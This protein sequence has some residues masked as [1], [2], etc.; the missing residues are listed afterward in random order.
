M[1]PEP[2]LPRYGERSLCEL[3]PAIKGTRETPG[4]QDLALALSGARATVLVVADGL[5]AL[6]L[7][8]FAALAPL[9]HA[10]Q[11]EPATSVAPSTTAAALTSLTTGATPGIHGIVGYRMRVND[12]VLQTLRWSVNGADATERYRPEAVQTTEPL[13][14]MGAAPVVYVGKAKYA[15]GGFTRA[16]LRGAQYLGVADL[17]AI[18]EQVLVATSLSPLVVAYHDAIDHVAHA[19]G[20]GQ[21]YQHEIVRLESMVTE[22]RHRLP[23]DVAIVVTADHGQRDVGAREVRVPKVFHP[24]IASMSGE[25]R[26][27]WLHA[28]LGEQRNL[29]EGLSEALA[30]SCWVWTRREAIALGLF[31]P[32]VSLDAEDRFG[33]VCLVPFIDAFVLD[34]TEPQEAHMR[35]RHG[36]LTPSE[37]YVP[38]IVR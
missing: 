10:S 11:L 26:F 9:L 24:F 23:P 13:L 16:H 30:D 20:L 35:G 4:A 12:D 31:G 25:G 2:I 5:G 22:L 7:D 29:A 1:A 36:S 18:V 15:Q 32:E 17:D 34:P 21:S 33:D 37:M 14:T 8:E 27:R 6:Q 3:L 28:V 19:D 38:V